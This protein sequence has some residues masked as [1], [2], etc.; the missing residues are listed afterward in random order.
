MKHLA[1]FVAGIFTVV[2]GVPL[3]V[4]IAAVVLTLSPVAAVTLWVYSVGEEM[5]G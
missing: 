2:I 4:A 3:L 1:R 5:I